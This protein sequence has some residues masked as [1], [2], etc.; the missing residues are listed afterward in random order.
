MLTLLDYQ[1]EGTINWRTLVL[2]G[3][4]VWAANLWFFWQGFKHFRLPAWMFIAVPLIFLQPQYADNTTWSISILQ[5]SV[6]I[7]W[8]SLLSYLCAQ[9]KYTWALVVA[10]AATFTHGNGFFSF[11]IIILLAISDR[12][13]KTVA[14]CAGIWAAVGLVYF[15]DFRTGQNADFGKSLSDPARLVMSFFAFFGSVTKIR[16]QNAYYAVS[17]GFLL[18]TVLG[19]YIIPKLKVLFYKTGYQ[20]SAFD[21]MLLGNILFLGIT[22]SLIAISR[23]WLGIDGILAPRY[24]H[25]SPYLI[26]WAYVVLLS[27]FNLR[28]RKIAAAVVTV[29]AVAFNALSYFTYHEQVQLRKDGLIADESNWIN[30]RTMIQYARSF[31]DNIKGVYLEA[32]ATG[33]CT[34][35]DQ[36]SNIVIADSPETDA[37]LRFGEATSYIIDTDGSYSQRFQ[38]IS[39]NHLTG[40]TYLFLQSGQ[41]KGYWVPTRILHSGIREFL[42]SGR[43]RKPGFHAEFLTENLPPADY[44]IGI[45]NDGQFSWSSQ[46]ILIK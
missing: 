25:Y 14:V 44:R 29:G 13:W 4:V 32:V 34:V 12:K 5:Q 17:L 19:V 45:L 8:F 37:N 31:N 10:I 40:T 1:I 9:Q 20:L 36:F 11:L 24:Q 16:T 28:Y 43:L 46:R 39:N 15:W 30:H 21:K 26:C 35:E 18:A 3:S 42:S 41:Q 33:I 22:G 6:I 23:S 27:F 38:S 7:F 2:L